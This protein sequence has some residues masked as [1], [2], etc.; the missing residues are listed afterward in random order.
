MTCDFFASQ[1]EVVPSIWREERNWHLF[2]RKLYFAVKS[3]KRFS[4]KSRRFPKI[5]FF[6]PLRIAKVVATIEI[7]EATLEEACLKK[8]RHFLPYFVE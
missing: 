1:I 3:T 5:N 6:L 7:L 2:F 8:G 4:L